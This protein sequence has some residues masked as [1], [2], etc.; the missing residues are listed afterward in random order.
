[1]A[2]AKDQRSP[3]QQQFPFVSTLS[4]EAELAAASLGLGA[5]SVAGWSDAETLLASQTVLLDPPILQKLLLYIRRRDD[6]LG[7]F[8]SRLRSPETRRQN[9]ATYTPT[10]IVSAMMDWAALQGTPARVVDP[11]AG[12]GRFLVAAGRRFPKAELIGIE[13]DP[14]AALMT[15]GHLAAAGFAKRSQVWLEDYRRIKLPLIQGR[16]LFVGN[17]PYVRHHL[18]DPNWKQWLTERSSKLGYK[19][20]QLAGLHVYFFLATVLNARPADYGC[21]ITAA[22]WLDVNYGKL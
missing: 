22:E 20:S 17:P 14:L 6:P 13:V 8:F 7:D 2:N 9:G 16:T 12:S 11:G 10:S 18:I 3:T 19:A 4:T 1:M 5:R 21:F 15:R